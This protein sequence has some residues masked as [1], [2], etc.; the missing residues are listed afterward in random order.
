M[1]QSF[2]LIFGIYKRYGTLL[3]CVV[4]VTWYFVTWYF[5]IWYLVFKLGETD[6]ATGAAILKLFHSHCRCLEQFTKK[7]DDKAFEV[8]HHYHSITTCSSQYPQSLRCI[9]I[10]IRTGQAVSEQC[11]LG[12]GIGTTLHF[13]TLTLTLHFITLQCTLPATQK[14]SRSDEH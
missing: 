4:F 9:Q 6:P 8:N 2:Y 12:I 13:I 10:N 1:V 7:L 14:R 5:V 3:R 11:S